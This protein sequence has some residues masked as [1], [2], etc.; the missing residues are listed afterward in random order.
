MW[1]K[2]DSGSEDSL[3]VLTVFDVIDK[4]ADFLLF[5]AFLER[6]IEA[7]AVV[8]HCVRVFSS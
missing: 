2:A 6:V 1:F 3:N 8:S 4:S 5:T 7:H